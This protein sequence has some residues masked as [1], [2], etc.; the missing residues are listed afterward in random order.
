MSIASI[1]IVLL[2]FSMF[3]GIGLTYKIISQFGLTARCCSIYY[4]VVLVCVSINELS[5]PI[6]N[7]L[8]FLFLLSR[9]VVKL[10]L[11][12]GRRSIPS[13]L[14]CASRSCR[15]PTLISALKSLSFLKR[16]LSRPG[17][18]KSK[19]A[20]VETIFPVA[21]TLFQKQDQGVS[22]IL[23]NVVQ[24][25]MVRIFGSWFHML[26]SRTSGEIWQGI[27]IQDCLLF[28]LFKQLFD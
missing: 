15:G 10:I 16:Y 12:Q 27:S 13:M 20:P 26:Y 11:S 28:V 24:L 8:I 6:T 1:I 21:G 19:N 23:S 5:F 14:E 4:L 18:S 22:N 2:Q 7:Q 9:E 3:I 17:Q 25:C